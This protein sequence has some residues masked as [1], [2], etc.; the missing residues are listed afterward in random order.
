MSQVV[1][2]LYSNFRQTAGVN[3]I[4]I[5]D[6]KDVRSLLNILVER[7]G[8]KFANQLFEEKTAKLR[9]SVLILV[10]GHSIKTERELDTP[11]MADDVLTTDV[12]VILEAV[13]GG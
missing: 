3:Q 9:K 6:A 5:A 13:G 8:D 2:K 10:N 11:L 12:V 7:F 4:R 1:V